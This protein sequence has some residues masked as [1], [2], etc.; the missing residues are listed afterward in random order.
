MF[1][2]SQTTVSEV[3]LMIHTYCVRFN[4]SDEGRYALFDMVKTWAGPELTNINFTKYMISKSLDPP[5]NIYQYVFYCSKCNCLLGKFIQTDLL[6]NTQRICEKC[7]ESYKISTNTMNYFLSIDV[8]FQ[9]KTLLENVTARKMLLENITVIKNRLQKKKVDTIKDVY[10]GQLYKNLYYNVQPNTVLLTFNFN[11]DG[12]PISKSSKNGIWPIQIIINELPPRVR[13]RYI[14]LAA[15]WMTTSEPSPQFMNLYMKVFI[16][17]LRD[18]MQNGV[19]IKLSN[20]EEITFV[21]KPLCATVDSVARPVIQNR[22]QFNGHYGC[23][24]CYQF[25]KYEN[26]AMRYPF[27]DEDPP[28]RNHNTFIQDMLQAEQANRFIMGVKGYAEITNLHNFDCVWGFPYDYMHT[29]LLGTVCTLW[30]KIWTVKG[31]DKFYLTKEDIKNVE[32]RLLNI[33]LPR[34]IHRIPRSFTAGKWK[35]SEWRSWVIYKHS[36][37]VR[38]IRNKIFKFVCITSTFN[39]H[40]FV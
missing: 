27:E 24:W 36:M 15:M 11:S 19:T 8:K 21:L 32:R 25:G 5:E 28:L 2:G 1:Q 4:V 23:S 33:R 22:L 34:E 10:D 17:Q 18:L 31:K 35:A 9:I 38:N 26:G 13:F 29:L 37:S 16:D 40:S 20:N 7:Q 3:I 12:A 30:T 39:T 14:L 6:S